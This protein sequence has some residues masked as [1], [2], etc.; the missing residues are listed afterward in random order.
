MGKPTTVQRSTSLPARAG[1]AAS[2]QTGLTQ[3]LKALHARAS[4]QSRSIAARVA[5]GLRS[6]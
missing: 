6:V 3:T 5:S 2:I 1:A 4:V